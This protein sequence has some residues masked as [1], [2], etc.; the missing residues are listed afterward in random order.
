MVWTDSDANSLTEHRYLF[1][2]PF[3][4]VSFLRCS[5]YPAL[6]E[7]HILAPFKAVFHS[8]TPGICS[9]TTFILRTRIVANKP[10]A[11]R[12]IKHAIPLQLVPQMWENLILWVFLETFPYRS[13]VIVCVL[14]SY[15]E[16]KRQLI[17]MRD[18]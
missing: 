7:Y 12:T 6:S 10:Y 18:E 11:A 5:F 14:H 13:L 16:K 9:Y 8:D 2:T 4:Q 17:R 3:F 1:C 15:Q